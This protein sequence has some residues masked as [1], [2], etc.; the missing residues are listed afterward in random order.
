MTKIFFSVISEH[1]EIVGAEA[2]IAPWFSDDRPLR[3]GAGRID[4]RM[5]EFF[6]KLVDRSS[7]TDDPG[8]LFLLRTDER[9]RATSVLLVAIGKRTDV[10]PRVVEERL[11]HAFSSALTL[12]SRQIAI[13][14]RTIKESV[15]DF[16]VSSFLAGLLPV[17]K[18]SKLESMRCS[19]LVD[20]QDLSSIRKDISLVAGRSPDVFPGP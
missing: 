18:T 11:I 5:C 3:G 12:G 17:V 19:L 20:S 7:V 13:C 16:S 6:S 10:N 1:A 9:V 15:S 2:L 8:S 4:W 14:L